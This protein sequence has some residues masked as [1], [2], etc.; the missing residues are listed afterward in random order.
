[1]DIRGQSWSPIWSVGGPQSPTPPRIYT[2]ALGKSSEPAGEVEKQTPAGSV[3]SIGKSPVVMAFLLRLQELGLSS[4]PGTDGEDS[5]SGWTRTL[6][7]SGNGDDSVDVWSGSV[8]DAG[9]GDDSVR[10]WSD[11]VVHGGAG[12]DQ[13]EVWS[14]STVDGGAGNDV[15]RAWSDTVVLGGTGDDQISAWSN[16][17]VDGGSGDD[18]IRAWSESHVEGGEGD[19][20]IDVHSNSVASGGRG[21]DV[22]ALRGSGSVAHFSAGDGRDTIYAGVDSRIELGTGLRPENTTVEIVGNVASIRFDESSDS[23]SVHLLGN[24]PTILSFADGTT[25]TLTGEAFQRPALKQ[26][27][28]ALRQ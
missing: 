5:L 18:T 27:D 15:I 21:D 23:I 3:D 1:M 10:A 8:V 2:G 11:A 17:K 13:L 9:A 19:D 14:G 16:S 24:R 20:V 26:L 7:D 12:D 25:M 28:V 6:V 22:V 4:M